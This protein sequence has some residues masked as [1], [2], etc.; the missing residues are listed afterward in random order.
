MNWLD[1]IV[2]WLSEVATNETV[3]HQVKH[4]GEHA[5]H[6]FMHHALPHLW[7]RLKDSIGDIY[8]FVMEWLSSV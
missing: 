1:D 3:V 5:F 2:R 4:M 8:T 7:A 6:S